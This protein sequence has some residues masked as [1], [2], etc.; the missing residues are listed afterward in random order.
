MNRKR[1]K[2][3]AA[4]L[5]LLSCT[6]CQGQHRHV[7]ESVVESRTAEQTVSERETT[8]ASLPTEEGSARTDSIADGEG[9]AS[10]SL[11]YQQI[12]QEEASRILEEESGYVLLDVRTLAEYTE[13]YIP[14]AVC[15]PNENVWE[16]GSSVLPD[17]EQ[18]ILVYCRS[19]RRSKEAA[20]KLSAMG[21]THVVEFG[22]ILTW[23]GE[24]VKGA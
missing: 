12:T 11:G 21:Y 8:S 7:T 2:W 16:E 22:G 15:L 9:T 23:T 20:A 6:A 3:L 19:G 24:L 5:L 18:L 10:L 13:G 1:W 14:R 4:G 17:K